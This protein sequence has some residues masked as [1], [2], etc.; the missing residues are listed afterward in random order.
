MFYHQFEG[1]KDLKYQTPE[2]G[3]SAE[4]KREAVHESLF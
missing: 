4:Q 1:A 3:E 2:T